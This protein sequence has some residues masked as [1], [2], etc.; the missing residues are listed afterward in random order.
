MPRLEP[1]HHLFVALG[2]NLFGKHWQRKFARITGLSRSYVNMI[3]KGERPVTK[4]VRLDV[5]AGLSN[6]INRRRAVAEQMELL[7]VQ[8]EE[9]DDA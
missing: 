9:D 8:Y 3:A 6:E 2:K 1:A 4:S 5:L 7:Y